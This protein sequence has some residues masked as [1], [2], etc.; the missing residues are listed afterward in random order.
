MT[1]RGGVLVFLGLVVLTLTLG[2]SAA[3]APDRTMEGYTSQLDSSEGTGTSVLIGSQGGGPEWKKHGRVYRVNGQRVVWNHSRA[4][5]NFGV[6][7]LSENRVVAGF[8]ERGYRTGCGQYDPP[9]IKTGY[10]IIEHNGSGNPSVVE[11]FSYPVRTATHSENHDVEPLGD[12]RFLLA[13]MENER[14]FIVENETV[15]WQWNGSSHYEAPADPTRRDWLHI[16]DVDVIDEGR[17]LVSV[18][19]ANQLLVIERGEEVVEVVNEDRDQRD[20]SCLKSN[21]LIDTDGDGDVKCGDPAVFNHQ[22][23]PQWLRNGHVLLADSENDRVIELGNQSGGWRPIWSVSE[24]GDIPL[25]WPRDADRLP[26]GNTIITDSLNKRV[27]IVQPDGTLTWS[28]ATKRIPYEAD[29]L[30]VGEP[31]NSGLPII[32][33]TEN[34]PSSQ[35]NETTTHPDVETVTVDRSEGVLQEFNGD[36]PG[37]SILLVGLQA[38]VPQLPFWFNEVQLAG[39]LVSLVLIGVGL[40]ILN[41]K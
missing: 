40:V 39:T 21:Q 7:R 37:L 4:D 12:G 30:G 20:A 3:T 6:V 36:I 33:Q 35:D 8:L 17:Y 10:R 23:N 19:N 13:D 14:I 27:F 2:I 15:T 26:N 41:R 22:H 18:R 28:Y 1:R 16:N 5:S 38:L 29:Y 11:E 24:A 32:S 25:D 31:A 34:Q 9:C